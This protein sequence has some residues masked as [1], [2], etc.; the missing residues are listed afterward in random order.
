MS[1]SGLARRVKIQIEVEGVDVSADINK[2]LQSFTYTDNE[3]DKADDV[4]IT[5]DDRENIWLGSWLKSETDGTGETQSTE[6]S[7]NE[8]ISYIVKRGDTL[9]EIASVYSTTYQQIAA[10]NNIKNPNLIYP[11]QVLK[12]N[13]TTDGSASSPSDTDSGEVNA[14]SKCLE[15]HVCI[16]QKNWDSDGK[17][18]VLDCGTFE[19]D[20]VDGSG[21]PAKVNIKGTSIPYT[22]TLR[23][24]KKTKAWE[25]IKLSSIVS[26][27]A[28]NND[29]GYMFESDYDP[30][31]ER[32]EQVQLSDI[33]FLQGLCKNAGISLK[34]TAKTIVL[35]DAKTYEAKTTVITLK[36]GSSD[37][38]SYKFSTNL[39]DTAYSSSHVTYTNP[40]TKETIDYTYTPRISKEGTGQVLEINEK[41]NTREEARQL[42]MKRLRQKNKTEFTADFTIVGNVGMV[43]GVTV[44]VAEYGVF[45][46]KYIVETATHNV[47]GGYTVGLKLRRVLEDY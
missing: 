40:T 27:I 36:R 25:K 10:D 23:T 46:G 11:G 22:S 26:E 15:V 42:A 9:S 7:K 14:G 31:Y 8:S 29:L 45:N 28:T 5:V 16:V 24:Q 3:E 6:D 37:I 41:V 21:P 20:S 43:A 34:V 47:T 44:E 39:K 32:K 2:Y 18:G 4:Q 38:I 35:F 17:D 13:T 19:I 33:S 12:I 1:D 30:L